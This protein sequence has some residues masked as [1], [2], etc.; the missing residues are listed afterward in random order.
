MGMG[1]GAAHGARGTE[2]RLTDALRA[3]DFARVFL[4]AP[5]SKKPRHGD[6]RCRERATQ[7]GRQIALALAMHPESN[8]AL[9]P[10][11]G[12]FVLDDDG[13]L[14]AWLAE[15]NLTLPHTMTARTGDG[16][17]HRW[18]TL[19]ASLRG[20]RVEGHQRVRPYVDIVAG[21]G[22]SPWYVV[23]PG[24]V[25]PDTGEL[26][27]WQDGCDP[28]SAPIAT[29]PAELVA[30]LRDKGLLVAPDA[31][32]EEPAADDGARGAGAD[33]AALVEAALLARKGTRRA[34][35]EL[36]F[37]CLFHD[38]EHAS[39]SYN[40]DSHRWYCHG[41]GARGGLRKLAHALG[42]TLPAGG[43]DRTR[44]A[45]SKLARLAAAAPWKGTGGATRRDALA[46]LHDRARRAGTLEIACSVRSLA[47]GIGVQTSTAHAA[48]KAHCRD[49]WLRCIGRNAAGTA[50]YRLG[51]PHSRALKLRTVALSLS[52]REILFGVC[53]L[54]T[55]AF[56]WSTGLGKNAARVLAVLGTRDFPTAAELAR[57]ARLTP[58]T[59][60]RL[61]KRLAAL[62]LV[63]RVGGQWTHGPAALEAV[64]P[65]LRSHGTGKRQRAL[66][67]WERAAHDQRREDFRDGIRRRMN[68]RTLSAARWRRYRQRTGA[69]RAAP[70]R[71][72][73]PM[74][75]RL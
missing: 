14:G 74:R 69:H 63:A 30:L 19:P 55:D 58:A 28:D 17:T 46:H 60:R 64:A 48:L 37:R 72:S 49:G 3:T 6:T 44:G 66:Y 50:V 75:L 40:T 23:G 38:D 11:P 57:T 62:G 36:R 54:G 9:I 65:T 73:A 27:R 22:G 15:H 2:Q 52:R 33:P 5:R 39:A 61:L 16:G 1:E 42:L 34:G 26:Y 25:H 35:D 53:T 7:D 43:D 68:E 13:G 59:A 71:N 45:V 31:A 70:E 10:L 8:T 51:E 18:F 20:W 56:R 29:A 67:A 24:S 21:G 47:I 41:C 12:L 32:A 4:L